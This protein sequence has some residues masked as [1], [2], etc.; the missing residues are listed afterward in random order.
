MADLKDKTGTLFGFDFRMNLEYAEAEQI[1]DFLKPLCKKWCFKGEEGEGGYKHWQGRL[2]LIVR[3]RKTTL[4]ILFQ[5]FLKENNNEKTGMYL[6]PTKTGEFEKVANNQFTY[7]EKSDT[8]LTQVYKDCIDAVY[9]PRQL[10]N[11]KVLYPWQNQIKEDINIFN[12]RSINVIFDPTGGIGKST[13]CSYLELNENCVDVPPITDS[14]YLMS[15]VCD[16]LMGKKLRD[17]K[18]LFFDLPRALNKDNL[19]S[20]FV[21]IEQIKKGK[22]Y[23]YR[24]HYKEWWIDSPNIWVFTNSLPNIN[25][26]SKDRWKIWEIKDKKLKAFNLLKII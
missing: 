23:D 18:A 12:E 13:I 20:M 22:L 16:I 4:L 6:E 25:L 7:I 17:P 9:I 5:K 26:L 14:H 10:R 15:S 19:T 1:I 2:S 3:K 11:I 8:Q 24:N 21:V